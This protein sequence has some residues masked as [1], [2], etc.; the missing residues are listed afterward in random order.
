[1]PQ[2]LQRPIVRYNTQRV[3]DDM[4]AK[5]WLVKDLAHDTGLAHTTVARFLRGEFQ[6]AKTVKKIARSLG[7][8]VRRYI[9][10]QG[11]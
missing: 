2:T 3:A 5:G 1:M 8:S 10:E 6:T 11:A 7:T 4:A 9:V